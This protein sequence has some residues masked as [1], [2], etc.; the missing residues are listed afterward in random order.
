MFKKYRL[1]MHLV[2]KNADEAETNMSTDDFDKLYSMAQEFMWT[3]FK[4]VALL[5]VVAG[6]TRL[7][8]TRLS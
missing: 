1:E 7:A 3:S 2:K 4:G 8:V 6:I 5:I